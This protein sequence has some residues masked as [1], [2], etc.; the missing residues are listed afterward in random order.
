MRSIPLLSAHNLELLDPL[1][2]AD[3]ADIDVPFGVDRGV[4]KMG[5]FAHL[6]THAAKPRE[7]LSA[8]TI[9][10]FDLLVVFIGDEHELLFPIARKAHRHSRAPST[11]HH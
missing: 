4:V 8:A 6:V 9:E 5:K 7:N 10:D 3:L 2:R 11:R 1:A